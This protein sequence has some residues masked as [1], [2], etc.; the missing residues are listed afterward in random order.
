[1]IHK[2]IEYRQDV[3]PVFHHALKHG[4]QFRFPRRLFVPLGE[5]CGGNLNVPAEL[6]GRVAAKKEPVEEGGF[7]LREFKVAKRLGDGRWRQR[8]GLSRHDK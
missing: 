5:D 3:A 7:A 2:R 1:M 6:I 4:A 8:I